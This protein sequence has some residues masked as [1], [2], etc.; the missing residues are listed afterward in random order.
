MGKAPSKSIWPPARKFL[1]S[2][3][4]NFYSYVYASCP[5]RPVAT[6]LNGKAPPWPAFLEKIRMLIIFGAFIQ[7]GKKFV[8]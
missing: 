8:D 3:Y 2:P 4:E 7:R 1:A 6:A 5:N